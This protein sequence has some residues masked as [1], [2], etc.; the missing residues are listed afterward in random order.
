MPVTEEQRYALEMTQLYRRANALVKTIHRKH[1][2]IR[3]VPKEM[4]DELTVIQAELQARRR[5]V[6]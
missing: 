5:A 3:P 2:A 1:A 4:L 6:A